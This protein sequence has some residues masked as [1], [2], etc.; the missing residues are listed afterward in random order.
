VDYIRQAGQS[1][2]G[3]ENEKCEMTRKEDKHA[4]NSVFGAL[5]DDMV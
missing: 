2:Q 1:L 4:G 5:A 3:D